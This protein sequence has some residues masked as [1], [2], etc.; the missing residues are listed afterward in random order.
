MKKKFGFTLA[1]VLI[2]LAIIGVVAALTTP[3]LVGSYQKSK[4]GPSLRKFSNTIETA[5]QHI[6]GDNDVDLITHTA[7]NTEE[8]LEK[9][10]K[11]LAG[12]PARKDNNGENE[13]PEDENAP[14][15]EYMS[16]DEL[17]IP[18]LDYKG[19][20]T[21]G[22]APTQNY[23]FNFDTN[24]SFS[25]KFVDNIDANRENARASYKG[26]IANV[27]YD[28]NGFET[29]PNR[30]GKDIFVFTLDNNGNLIPCGGR[31]ERDAYSD[32]DKVMWKDG[33]VSL[34]CNEDNAGGGM[35]CAGSIADND[36]K[37][38]YKY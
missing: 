15:S 11:Y 10:S 5:N 22:S 37:V 20:D 38:I 13:N 1:E 4:V 31:L 30:L 16:L 26:K 17:E 8:Y 29:K 6:M 2:T 32:V 19:Q 28:L 34:Q 33:D 7:T 35:T 27:Y 12:A 18:V 36:W 21:L 9:L 25:I 23:I 3:T 14:Q 24:D